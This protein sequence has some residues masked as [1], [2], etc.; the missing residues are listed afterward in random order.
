ML[1]IP[2]KLNK[3]EPMSKS[4]FKF[5]IKHFNKRD[6]DYPPLNKIRKTKIKEGSIVLD[7]GCGPGS[8]SIAAAQVVGDLGKVYAADIHPLAIDEVK[9][10]VREKGIKNIE[11]ILTNRDTN[12]DEN[13]IDVVLLLDIYHHLS[14]P[15][16]ILEELYRVL[17]KEGSLSVDDH[18]FKDDEIISK[19]TSTKLFKFSEKKEELFNFKKV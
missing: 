13:S 12:L 10:R 4:H 16:S 6:K 19:I 8:Y 2:E 14:D 15:K 18:H 11:T 1:S 17:K 3:D 9:N 5:M 7:Y